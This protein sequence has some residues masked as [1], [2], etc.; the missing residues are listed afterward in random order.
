MEW[1]LKL[2]E[3]LK[4]VELELMEGLGGDDD[5]CQHERGQ[6]GWW[7]RQLMQVSNSCICKIGSKIKSKLINMGT[8]WVYLCKKKGEGGVY[9]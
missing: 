9:E 5:I 8:L 4:I 6:M 3:W 1:I 7:W 2:V